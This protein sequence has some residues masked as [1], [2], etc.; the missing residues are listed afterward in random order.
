MSFYFIFLFLIYLKRAHPSLENA[1]DNETI[2]RSPQI[3]FVNRIL[4]RADDLFAYGADDM[5][6]MFVF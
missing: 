1:I 3:T 6:D 4:S 5:A 2:H